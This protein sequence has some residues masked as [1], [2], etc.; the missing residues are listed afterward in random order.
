MQDYQ[1]CPDNSRMLKRFLRALAMLGLA[2]AGLCA[3]A[4][5][6]P[7]EVDA[8]LSRAKIPRD[9]VSLLVVDTDRNNPVPPRLCHLANV[10]RNPASVMKLVTTYAA[11][12]LLGPAF[13]W[14]TPVYLDG[15]FSNGVLRGN[16][17]IKGQ[18]DPQ[19]V[20]E[21][22]WLL[23]RRLQGLGVNQID[24]DIVLDHSAFTLPDRDP[25]RFDGEPLRPYNASADA[26]LI[27]YKSLLITI[28][29]DLAGQRA[30]VQY[31]PPLF[32][33]QTQTSVPL[34]AGACGD[35]RAQL[36][37]DF[38]NPLQIRLLGGYPASCG[39]KVWPVAYA[40]PDSFAARTVQGLWLSMGGK[41]N[42]SVHS[43]KVPD[44]LASQ[45]PTLESSSA[46]LAEVIRD[47]NK[48]SNNVMAKQLFLTLGLSA[49]ENA[50]TYDGA[51]SVLQT[52]WQERIGG[53]APLVENGAGLSRQDRISAQ[54]L[55]RL[56]R[57]AYDSPLMS[58]LMSSLPING[59]DGTLKR[60]KSQ[61]P[62]SAHLKSG[63]LTGVTARAGYVEGSSGKRYVLVALINH[64]NANTEAASNVLQALIDW[65]AKDD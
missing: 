52:W 61:I 16:V 4:Q 46:P 40:D 12:D 17:Y 19:L 36:K 7:A 28:R 35:Y 64:T 32:G 29:P 34:T 55:A 8:A 59:V 25:A 9:A 62:G 43:G 57:T 39:E 33:V 58:E 18:G 1:G 45:P 13:Q 2:C 60:H 30:V 21:R 22:L 37:A 10:P 47:I 48:Y 14:T 42:G 23:L 38:S 49:P 53:V 63:T 27:N 26:L 15:T 44:A 20:L 24:G 31:D 5:S 65:T 11:L 6:L 50:G 56:L 41:L 3:M 54:S 51:R